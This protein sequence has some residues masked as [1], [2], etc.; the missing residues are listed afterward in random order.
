MCS[1][2]SY[3]HNV[4]DLLLLEVGVL[5]NLLD[6]LHGL[7]EQ[8]QVEFFEFRPRESLGEILSIEERFDFDLD[9]HLGGES[10]L[11]L[12]DF[13]LEFT[14]SSKVR[15]DVSSVVL[16]LPDLDEVI[17]DSVVE[18]LSSKMG[19]SGRGED[20]ENSIVD[21]KERDVESSS[22]EI[23]DDNVS[24]STGL[25]ESVSDRGGGRFV[26]NSENVKSSDSSCVLGSLTLSV[27]EAVLK[28][29]T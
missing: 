10:S 25:V 27:V 20:F 17:D 12:L 2:D 24:F 15:R 11:G 19:V 7:P 29:P 8:I 4:I 16:P 22:S 1:D 23:V 18:V 5:E 28:N 26:D 13:P 21:R 3:L 6:G 9:T 14:H